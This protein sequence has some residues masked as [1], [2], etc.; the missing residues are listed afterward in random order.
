MV[1]LSHV[2]YLSRSFVR[3][4]KHFDLIFPLTRHLFRLPFHCFIYFYSV[5]RLS[6]LRR[7]MKRCIHLLV[8]MPRSCRFKP[9]VYPIALDFYPHLDVGKLDRLL[10]IPLATLLP[11][12]SPFYVSRLRLGHCMPQ[13][14]L[15]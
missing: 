6:L 1:T 9:G 11:P 12:P 15:V 5:F 4:H 3:V 13:V 14:V 10:P 8:K 7:H 2:Y